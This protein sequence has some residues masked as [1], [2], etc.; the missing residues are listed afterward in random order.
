MLHSFARIAIKK[1]HWLGGL[2]QQKFISP[3]FWRLDVQDQGARKSGSSWGF[4]PYL[5]DGCLLTVSSHGPSSLCVPLVCLVF[6]GHQS[7]IRAPQPVWSVNGLHSICQQNWK[8]Q[9]WS[10]DWKRS[11]F[12]P[13]PKKDDVKEYS[14]YCTIAFISHTSKVRLKILQA[15]L[16][17][18]M[19]F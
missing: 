18:Y 2:K 3:Q 7:W 12:F 1:Q 17:Q 16:Q 9:Q 11:V 14:N 15:R 5:A 8:T 6:Q 10:Q 13:I 19:N 4:S